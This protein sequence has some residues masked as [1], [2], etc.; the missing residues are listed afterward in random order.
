MQMKYDQ[1]PSSDIVPVKLCFVSTFTNY[2]LYP[3]DETIKL[4]TFIYAHVHTDIMA[5]YKL[6]YIFNIF[7]I[8]WDLIAY[9]QVKYSY[10]FMLFTVNVSH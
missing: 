7:K 10:C 1:T 8:I 4:Q 6:C 3:Y 5:L 2:W 9:F